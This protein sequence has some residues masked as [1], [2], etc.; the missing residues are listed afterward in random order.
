MWVEGFDADAMLARLLCPRCGHAGLVAPVW[1]EEVKPEDRYE[2]D[3]IYCPSVPAKCP[4]CGLVGEAPPMG[5]EV[6]ID[7]S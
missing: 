3:T 1:D 6:R 2:G 5:S 7:A 4:A